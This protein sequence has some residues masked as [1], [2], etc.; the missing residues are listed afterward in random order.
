M[1]Q[2]RGAT[3]PPLQGVDLDL[4]LGQ[5]I[6]LRGAD[7]SG[8]RELAQG[9]LYRES[10]RRYA[11][12]LSAFERETL[13]GEGPAVA[14]ELSGLPPALYLDGVLRQRQCVAGVLQL[15]GRLGRLWL[16]QGQARCPVCGGQC[17][18]A[19]PEAAAQQV[20][21][22]F[23]GEACLVLAPVDLGAALA[24]ELRRAGFLRLRAEGRL[25]R[26]DRDEIPPG[27]AEVVL[28]RVEA[29]AAHRS[30]LVEACRQARALS[31]GRSLF[32]GARSGRQLWLN[33]PFSCRDCGR[34]YPA[35]A[36]PDLD[37]TPPF[38]LSYAGWEWGELRARDLGQVGSRLADEGVE[39]GMLGTLNE[40]RALGLGHLPLGRPVELLSTGEQ[41]LLQ[42]AWSLS[43]G[44]TGILY[45]FE[46][47]S[48]GLDAPA[49]RRLAAGLNRLVEQGNTAVVLD[50]S[51]EVLGVAGLVCHWEEGRVRMGGV[52][53]LTPPM[54][55]RQ[56]PPATRWLQV[57]HPE[58]DWRLPLGCMVVM[59]G[60][61]GAGKTALWS[62]VLLPGLQARRGGALRLVG[63][64]GIQ[65]VAVLGRLREE[66]ERLLLDHLGIFPGLAA[67]YAERSSARD[68]G[69]AP[70]WFM[71]SRPGGRC[72]TCEGKGALPG[73][74][75][76]GEEI[77]LVCPACE[78]RRYRPEA[79]EPTWR[80][81]NLAQLLEL[82]VA[83]AA[84]HCR[85]V[86]QV[87]EA[88][89][90]ALACGLG[91]RRLGESARRLGPAEILR[92]ELA[93]QRRRAGPRELVVLEHPEA[94]GHPGDLRHLGEILGE[95]CARGTTVLVETHHPQLAGAADWLVE[96]RAGQPPRSGPAGA[97]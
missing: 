87:G 56:T 37:S 69:Y 73:D 32:A 45:L 23:G 90:A 15:E 50:H 42:L 28:D 22:E 51:E 94:G 80:G 31:R 58:G 27:P 38:H 63:R 26:L 40:A 67:Q 64:P 2:I 74:L 20:I 19:T 41:Q 24:E 17:T 92:L 78:G 29:D 36:V 9:V 93:A 21:A 76:L 1:I 96:V 16:E 79:L 13:G 55:T 18:A 70:E 72:P 53:V 46:S 86:P 49:K 39:E 11:Q 48:R 89:Q 25:L 5:V 95:L 44:L 8:A 30:R 60:P 71:L 77:S 6:C 84:H 47:P 88:L 12:V 52:E 35:V 34:C 43:L 14:G 7:G 65:R 83:E 85:G 54:R 59:V 62:Q 82:R 91:H 3:L 10:R 75:G 97:A 81:L 33:Q 61:T 66:P 4:P 68:Q 57:A